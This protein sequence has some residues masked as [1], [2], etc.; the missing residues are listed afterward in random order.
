MSPTVSSSTPELH[1]P[2]CIPK[3]HTISL[4]VEL[5]TPH[6]LFLIYS[7]NHVTPAVRAD[8]FSVMG[9]GSQVTHLWVQ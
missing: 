2:G 4:K 3:T 9:E 8:I 5:R 1:E 7:F 6:L